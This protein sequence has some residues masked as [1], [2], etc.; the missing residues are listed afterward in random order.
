MRAYL[1]LVGARVLEVGS[2]NIVAKGEEK[3]KRRRI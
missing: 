3:E 1:G 2:G